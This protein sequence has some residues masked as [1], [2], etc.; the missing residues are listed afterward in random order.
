M[1][2]SFD[3]GNSN[4]NKHVRRSLLHFLGDALS[5]LTGTATRKDVNN[6]KKSV[7]QLTATRS[8]QQEAILHIASILNVTKYAA[9]VNRQD[10]NIVMDKS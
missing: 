8:T 3:D 4:Y 6:I 2:P 7:N 1:D 10:I 5:W 9:Q